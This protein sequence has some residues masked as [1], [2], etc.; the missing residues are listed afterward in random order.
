M[1]PP[2]NLYTLESLQKHDNLTECEDGTWVPARPLRFYSVIND[3]KL[4]WLVFRRKA[5]ALVWPC[6]Q[7]EAAPRAEGGGE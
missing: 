3:L 1:K 7:G 5:D 6:N 2:Y 4:A